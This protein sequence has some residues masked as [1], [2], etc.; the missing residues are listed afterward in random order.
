MQN[1]FCNDGIDGIN[2]CREAN[3]KSGGCVDIIKDLQKGRFG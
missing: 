2:G 1:V 3:Q